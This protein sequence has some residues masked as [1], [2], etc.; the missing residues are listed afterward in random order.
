MTATCERGGCSCSATAAHKF[1]ARGIL[2]AHGNSIMLGN[3]RG[4][5]R[6]WS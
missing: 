2:T 3:C 1:S 5:V 6:M 4:R